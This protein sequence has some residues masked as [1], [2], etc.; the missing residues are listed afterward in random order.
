MSGVHEGAAQLSDA[1]SRSLFKLEA[2]NPPCL[3]RQSHP[4]YPSRLIRYRSQSPLCQ[5]TYTPRYY[6]AY[7][8]RLFQVDALRAFTTFPGRESDAPPKIPPNQRAVVSVSRSPVKFNV[9]MELPGSVTS[10][11]SAGSTT[12]R[13]RSKVYAILNETFLAA[14]RR[15]N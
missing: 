9:A 11:L 2:I 12:L 14:S 3:H 13:T 5:S 15:A 4:T 7:N 8:A 6:P 1:L 10:A